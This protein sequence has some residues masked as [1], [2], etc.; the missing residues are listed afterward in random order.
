MSQTHDE[1]LGTPEALRQ[2]AALIGENWQAIEDWLRGQTRFVFLGC[3]SSY[4]LARSMAV[5]VRMRTGLPADALAAG[6][7][8]IHA[9]RYAACLK[10]AAVVCVSRSGHTS[11][12]VMALDAMKP[13]GV[14][15]AALVCAG[16]TPVEARGELTLNMPW[17]FDNSV[18]QTRTVTNFYFAA[19]TILAKMTGD[20]A[21]LA[22]LRHVVDNC[23]AFLEKAERLAEKIA[24]RDWTHGV[25]LAD[26]ELEGI[27]DEGALTFKEIC[28]LPSNYYHLLDARH[29]PMVLFH[30]HTLLVAAPGPK[31]G[32]ELNFLSEMVGRGAQVVA[33]TDTPAALPGIECL[34]YGRELSHI[35]RGLPLIL[36]C[37][38]LTFHKAAYTGANPDRPSGLD[39]WINLDQKSHE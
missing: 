20:E 26:A 33:V 21:L 17:A 22:D 16:G 37:Q 34:D 25:V 5:M 4:S 12:L 36:F 15:V 39:A 30:E 29:G 14:S 24:A 32:L 6:D 18:C 38:L 13:F 31:S 1:I 27:A 7:F 11:E 10:G 19:A 28:Q 2:T 3:G 35:A 9:E 8:L 23:E